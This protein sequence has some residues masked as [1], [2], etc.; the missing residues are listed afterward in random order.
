M[1]E[2]PRLPL[3]PGHTANKHAAVTERPHVVDEPLCHVFRRSATVRNMEVRARPFCAIR[4]WSAT[5]KPPRVQVGK[6]SVHVLEE[7]IG[8]W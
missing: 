5:E 2:F 7:T 4:G 6:K 1:S 8:L 3:D